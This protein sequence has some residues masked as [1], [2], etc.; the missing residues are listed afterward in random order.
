[1][2]HNI[3]LIVALWLMTVATAVAQP[4]EGATPHRTRLIPYP[5][6]QAAKEGS[7]AKNRYMQPIEEWLEVNGTLRGEFTYPFSWVER[8]I[9]IRIEGCREPYEVWINGKYKGQ[10]Q[11]GFAPMELN[12]TKA[13]KEDKNV[14]ELRLKGNS[15]TNPIESFDRGTPHP[16]AYIISQPR[17][18]VRDVA[19]RTTIEQSGVV[20]ADFNVIMQ[21]ETLGAKSSELYYEI[22]L[23]DTLRLTGGRL[24]VALGMYG[25]DTMRFGAPIPDSMLWSREHPTRLSLQ[26]KNRIAGRDVEFYNFALG[27]RQVEFQN[28]SY[29]INKHTE[30]IDWYDLSPRTTIAEME[31]MLRKGI[32]AVRFTAGYVSDEL[33]DF[34]DANGIYVALTAPINSSGMGSSRKRGGNPSNNPAWREEYVERTQQMIHTTK[35]HPSVIAYFLADDS[36]NGI[37]LYE[38]YLA[39][40]AITTTPIFY[41]D[42]GNEWNSDR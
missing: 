26:L 2:K 6:A 29:T 40:K 31:E 3:S 32:E 37:C 18:R 22:Y 1:M 14:V 35:R 34:C 42:G 10:S 33:L 13:S 28:G 16:K 19:W 23:N 24:N 20:N 5:T 39:A 15:Q 36:S 25:V 12:I 38:S 21:N 4:N 17:V 30:H 7:L 9:Y 41:L 11:N 8:Q 27:M